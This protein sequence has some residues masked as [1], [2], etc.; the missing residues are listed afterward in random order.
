MQ[1]SQL[2]IEHVKW[3]VGVWEALTPS[4]SRTFTWTVLPTP[5]EGGSDVVFYKGC[6]AAT[7]ATSC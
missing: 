6:D 4:D 7:A 5:P 3:T 2:A 1:I